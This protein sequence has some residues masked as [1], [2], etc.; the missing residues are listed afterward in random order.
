MKLFQNAFLFLVLTLSAYSQTTLYKNSEYKYQIEFPEGWEYTVPKEYY[1]VVRCEQIKKDT[2][3][4][5]S[6]PAFNIIVQHQDV[7]PNLFESANGTLR[8]L[9]IL[10]KDVI[11]NERKLVTIDSVNAVYQ[12]CTFSWKKKGTQ[13]KQIQTEFYYYYKDN[14]YMVKF[15]GSFDF[16]QSNTEMIQKCLRSFK[17]L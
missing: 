11:E 12:E 10:G 1:H 9:N 16:Y 14:I 5:A 2:L 7:F 6:Q 3:L 17:F 8:V 4:K 13:G 15:W